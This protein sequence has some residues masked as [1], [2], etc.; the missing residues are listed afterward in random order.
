MLAATGSALA[1]ENPWLTLS[2]L[3]IERLGIGLAYPEE[4]GAVELASGPAEIVIPPAQ[5][6][7]VGAPVNGVITRLL[8]AE[9]EAVRAGQALAEIQS[10]DLLGLERDYIAALSERSLADAQLDR[11]RG[12]KADGIIADKRLQE[13]QAAARS[14]AVAVDQAR[15]R[16]LLAGLTAPEL[17]R[18]AQ[19]Q[20][21]SAS[22]TLRAPF[23]GVAVAQIADLG[24]RVDT[25]DPIYRIADLSRLWL[26]MHVPQERTAR[27]RPGHTAVVSVDGMPLEA[28]LTHLSQVVDTASQT[29][30][31]R[32]E[33]ENRELRLRAGQFLPARIF[34]RPDQTTGPV[35]IVPST[36]VVREESRAFVFVRVAEGFAVRAITTMADDGSF[37]YVTDGIEPRS[38]IAVSGV[39]ALKSIWFEM[40]L[41]DEA[42]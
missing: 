4:A 21:L 28:T 5:Q 23:D 1:S 39:A 29:V 36:A 27:M 9:G 11:D 17:E 15:Q 16:L 26:E 31:T 38:E 32:A 33:I 34:F 10:P 22:L 3:E 19:D 30:L 8:V 40:R 12:L 6:S 2:A 41:G 35:L 25:L 14:A 42:P 7:I 24:A 20:R 18:L 13:T 37:V